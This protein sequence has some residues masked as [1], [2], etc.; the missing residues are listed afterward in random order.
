MA[1]AAAPQEGKKELTLRAVITGA[2]GFLGSRIAH[3]LI[4]SQQQK[5]G[6]KGPK[7][8]QRSSH[9]AEVVCI[10]RPRSGIPPDSLVGGNLKQ[11][12]PF[13]QNSSL[14]QSWW[15]PVDDICDVDALVRSALSEQPEKNTGLD[16][17]NSDQE[18]NSRQ[19]RPSPLPIVVFHVAADPSQWRGTEA[20]QREANVTGTVAVLEL[21]DYLR[22]RGLLHRLVVTSTQQVKHLNGGYLGSNKIEDV[23][24]EESPFIELQSNSP[25]AAA[26]CGC[27]WFTGYQRSKFVAE[28]LVREAIRKRKLPAVILYPSHVCGAGD[29]SSWATII[30]KIDSRELRAI[31][32]GGGCFASGEEVAAAHIRAA[33]IDCESG[34]SWMLGGPFHRWKEFADMTSASLVKGSGAPPAK[35]RVIPAFLLLF[36]GWLAS[37]V[38]V[39]TGREP[40]ITRE[41]AVLLSR[42]IRVESAKAEREL[43][44]RQRPLGDSVDESV[45]WLRAH[46]ELRPDQPKKDS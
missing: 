6:A 16:H 22:K 25:T 3:Q 14:V 27:C 20:R 34:S 45:Q 29:T 13:P 24:T 26:K 41:K 23:L 7:T 19:S 2:N 38:S 35:F 4:R 42:V 9:F 10:K 31:G 18:V 15:S 32:V 11:N 46:G 43:S 5:T 39:L 12:S 40:M 17:K 1:A 44:Y 8:S 33:T 30:K 28:E 37:L 36:V 21:C